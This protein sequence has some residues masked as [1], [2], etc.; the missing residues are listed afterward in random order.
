MFQYGISGCGDGKGLVVFLLVFIIAVA[1]FFGIR[2]TFLLLAICVLEA[3][4]L[5]V[6]GFATA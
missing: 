1:R 2:V 4:S 6:A 3:C 5:S